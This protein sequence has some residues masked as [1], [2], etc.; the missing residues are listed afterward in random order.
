MLFYFCICWWTRNDFPF[1]YLT[2]VFSL[3]FCISVFRNNFC[4]NRFSIVSYFGRNDEDIVNFYERGNEIVFLNIWILY[5]SILVN[6]WTLN[7]FLACWTF[8]F[9][10]SNLWTLYFW[11]YRILN[12]KFWIE[13][14]EF[15][16]LSLWNF[17]FS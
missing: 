9:L 15:E 2:I 3:Y 16:I 17:V 14:W 11:K 8:E 13:F 6:F 1:R 4:D 5:D 12:F 10:R 7:I